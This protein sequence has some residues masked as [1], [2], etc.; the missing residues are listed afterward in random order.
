M[1]K[2]RFGVGFVL[3]V[4]LAYA[5][6]PA[7]KGVSFKKGDGKIDVLVDGQPFT[8]YHFSPDLP[9]PFF[10]PLRAADG[11]V[12]TR[13][14][15][16]VTD[17]IGESKDHPHHRSNWFTHGDVNGVDYWSEGGKIRGKIVLRS[18]EMTK[19]GPEKGILASTLDW[20]DNNGKKVLVQNQEVVFRG[21]T[22]RRAMD[23]TITLMPAE[24]AV[25]FGD[26]KEGSFSIRVATPFE[27]KHGGKM[28]NS[29]GAVGEK[30]CW[31]KNAEWIDYVGIVEGKTLGIAIM[32]HPMSFRHPTTWHARAYGLFA[33]NPFGL[34]DFTGDK[35][36]D[37]SYLLEPGKTLKLRYR[38]LIH[39]G[40]TATSKITE[41]YRK[42]AGE[43][44]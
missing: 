6:Q 10:H 16:M 36:R 32:D 30:N 37:G 11:T 27:E 41:E 40:D 26:T 35:T 14:Y 8:T 20:L 25:K 44:K 22:N 28:T 42:Y 19:G 5:L 29:R 23:W 33:V 12:V 34:S 39:S 4:S 15:P 17:I 18:V 24:G 3:F 21:D 2:I 38:V 7:N 9:R 1:R 13:G 31:G 43:T